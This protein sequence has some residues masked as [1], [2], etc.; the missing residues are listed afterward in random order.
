M[1]QVYYRA[2]GGVVVHQG[3]V[4][5]L[6][7]P[8]RNE[9]RLPKGHIEEGESPAEAALR[10]VHEEAGYANLDVVADLGTQHAQ[11]VDPFRQRQVTRDEYYFLMRLRDEGQIEQDEHEQQFIP[12]WVL[13]TE[14]VTRLTFEAEREFVRRA[15]RWM[16]KE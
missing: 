16:A 3:K 1:Q 8:S 10:E 15:L 13:P 5:L 6:D 11:F 7:R 14:A 12:V 4:L 9:V 2:A